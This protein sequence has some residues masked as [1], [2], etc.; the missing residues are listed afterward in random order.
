VLGFGKTA[1]DNMPKARKPLDYETPQR[2]YDSLS[3][4]RLRSAYGRGSGKLSKTELLFKLRERMNRNAHRPRSLITLFYRLWKG[5]DN[6]VSLVHKQSI[7]QDGK[8][9]ECDFIN[10]EWLIPAFRQHNHLLIRNQYISMLGVIKQARSVYLSII[11]AH[12]LCLPVCRFWED[13]HCG[14]RP[15]WHRFVG[16]PGLD[17]DVLM[18]VFARK[19]SILVLYIPNPPLQ[20]RAHYP[21]EARPLL[22]L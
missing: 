5:N 22:L 13:A 16:G 19:N 8:S 11:Q 7:V 4:A 21:T 1:L 6:G 14:H 9:I 17:F 18:V 20:W 3:L 15:S 10:Q 2:R 12:S